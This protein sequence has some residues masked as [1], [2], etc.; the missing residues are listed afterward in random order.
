MQSGG[1]E[2]GGPHSAQN[3]AVGLRLALQFVQ[4]FAVA[5]PHSGQNFAPTWTALWQF[6][7][8]I[9]G[10]A[11]ARRG[12][13]QEG[14]LRVRLAA[15]EPAAALLTGGSLLRRSPDRRPRSRALAAAG[16]TAPAPGA[17]IILPAMPMPMPMNI[18]VTAPPPCAMPSPA[19]CSASACAACRKPPARRL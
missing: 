3:F 2:R 16:Y 1:P 15:P 19:P 14:P 9:V 6:L 13:P 10:A 11:A 5:V 4:C 7:H 8:A 12:G 18:G 17:C